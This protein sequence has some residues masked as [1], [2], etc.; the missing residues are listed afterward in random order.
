MCVCERARAYIHTHM[1][2]LTQI[3]VYKCS[4]S[5]SAD[6]MQHGS[7]CDAS[8]S[9]PIHPP[10]STKYVL[11]RLA[12]V[13]AL[14]VLFLCGW[15][16]PSHRGIL[17]TTALLFLFF[18]RALAPVRYECTFIRRCMLVCVCTNREKEGYVYERASGTCLSTPDAFQKSWTAS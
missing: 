3:R 14:R 15:R 8:F 11:K 9:R 10:T 13:C 16:R 17:Y 5:S 7:Q 2:H 6:R 4:S 1:M 12:A 18:L